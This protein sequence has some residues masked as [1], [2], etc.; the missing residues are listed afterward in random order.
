MVHYE[1]YDAAKL[2]SRAYLEKFAAEES[3]QAKDYDRGGTRRSE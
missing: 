1:R 2:R 3:I